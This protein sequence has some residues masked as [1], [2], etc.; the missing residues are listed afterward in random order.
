[1]VAVDMV[2]LVVMVVLVV[3]V[4]IVFVDRTERAN[5]ITGQPQ[6]TGRTGQTKLSLLTFELNFPGNLTFPT[7][8]YKSFQT[9]SRVFKKGAIFD[10][11]I[12]Y[13]TVTIIVC[14]SLV[15]QIKGQTRRAIEMM[16]CIA[17][18]SIF[19]RFDQI[20]STNPTELKQPKDNNK[21]VN[22]VEKKPY[23]RILG[24]YTI[25]KQ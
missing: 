3:R 9:E 2:A 20:Q 4:V 16:N 14:F 12:W 11:L 21:K 23:Y 8:V 10:F 7:D 6:Q 5:R 1:M 24:C 13:N 25:L 15:A 22:M 17:K 19:C 18:K